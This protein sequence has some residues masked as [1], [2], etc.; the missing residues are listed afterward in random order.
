M[1]DA[2]VESQRVSYL[3]AS[4]FT[5]VLVKSLFREGV[6]GLRSILPVWDYRQKRSWYATRAY[7]CPPAYQNLNR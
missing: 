4:Q 1:M 2:G 3:S 6:Q 7:L 5:R